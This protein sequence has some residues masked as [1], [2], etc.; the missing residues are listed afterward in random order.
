MCPTTTIESSNGAASNPEEIASGEIHV[1]I[2]EGVGF[3]GKHG[4]AARMVFLPFAEKVPPRI[5]AR[6]AR[7]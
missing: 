6:A 3:L 5:Q 1:V 4:A 2:D 7:W